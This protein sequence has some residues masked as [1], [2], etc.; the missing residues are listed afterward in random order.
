MYRDLVP[1]GPFLGRRRNPAESN[2]LNAVNNSP[3]SIHSTSGT[4]N[5]ISSVSTTER[6]IA[7]IEFRQEIL[8]SKDEQVEY[9]KKKFNEAKNNFL[10]E[11]GEESKKFVETIEG[12]DNPD[13]LFE[14]LKELKKE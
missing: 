11:G 13:Q 1:Y 9:Y 5:S 6:K 2:S 8:N 3:S 4:P 14:L 10:K 12:C 7:L